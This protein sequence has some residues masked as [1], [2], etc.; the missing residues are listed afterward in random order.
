MLESAFDGDVIVR[1]YPG[2]AA[3]AAAIAAGPGIDALSGGEPPGEAIDEFDFAGAP[4]AAT[5][6]WPFLYLRE[7]TLPTH[8]LL[9]LLLV[10]AWGVLLVGRAAHRSGTPLRRFSPHFFVLGIA[11]LLLETRSIVTFSLLFGSTWLVNALVFFAVL[12]SVLLAILVTSRLTLRRPHLL[13]V[14]LMASIGLAFLLPPG[15][16]LVDPPWLRYVLAAAL[17]FA[18]VFFA[19]L[20]FSYSFRDT[21]TADMAFAS[22]LLGAMVGGAIEYVALITGYQA[23]LVIVAALYVGAYLLATRVR[24]LADTDLEPATAISR[25]NPLTGEA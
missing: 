2:G 3:S 15:S 10:L 18:P 11:F 19:N 17:A 4:R 24:F 16:L 8:Y 7:P 23:L 5:D 21:K 25:P 1:R 22:N 13:Y 6:D 14:A 9:A 12:A 20:V